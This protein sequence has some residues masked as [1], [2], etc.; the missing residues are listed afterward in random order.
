MVLVFTFLLEAHPTSPGQNPESHK[1]VVV[2]VVIIVVVVAVVV[3][4]VV[5]VVVGVVSDVCCVVPFCM[6]KFHIQ[7]NLATFAS[8]QLYLML[9]FHQLCLTVIHKLWK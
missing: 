1:M 5:A 3:V 9:N 6:V 7:S 2:V 4:V 8:L